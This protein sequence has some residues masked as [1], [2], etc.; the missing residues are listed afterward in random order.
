MNHSAS[1]ERLAWLEAFECCDADPGDLVLAWQ[2]SRL[3]RHRL[4]VLELD[5]A[6]RLLQ[7]SDAPEGVVID[8]LRV[9]LRRAVRVLDRARLLGLA[10]PAPRSLSTMFRVGEVG[11]EHVDA[12]VAAH[13]ALEPQLREAFLNETSAVEAA[14]A[15]SARRFA[16]RLRLVAERC[17]RQR[18][19]DLLERQRRA[20]H[21]RTWIDRS[22]GMWHVSGAFDPETAIELSAR[23]QTELDRLLAAA[24]LPGEA[25]ERRQHVDRLRSQA[26]A[27]LMLGQGTRGSRGSEV[28][29]VVDT[30]QRNEFGEPVLDWGLPVELPVEALVRFFERKPGVAVV[31]VA[32]DG[33]LVDRTDRLDLGRET[34]L[35]NRAQR[36]ALRG[37]HATCVVPGCSVPFHR[38][39]IHHVQWWR[40]GGPTD[41]DNLAPLCPHHHHRIHD[42]GWVLTLDGQGKAMVVRSDGHVMT[43]GPPRGAEAA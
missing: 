43:T 12:F 36:R 23:L 33:A 1:L 7:V 20:A 9:P 24:P 27:T 5:F 34:R 8:V 10:S 31:D 40:N 35:A 37:L 32:R 6:Q 29:V 30:T 17:R 14:G 13:A 42:D 26:L 4:D 28:L 3:L 15:L 41:L 11:L 16:D 25:D 22:T 19:L 18:G 21:L 2:A 38:C 39:E